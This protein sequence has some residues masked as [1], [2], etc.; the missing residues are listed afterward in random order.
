MGSNLGRESIVKTRTSPTPDEIFRKQ[1]I[2][3]KSIFF[4]KAVQKMKNRSNNPP[5]LKPALKGPEGS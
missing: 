1:E 4:E 2:I 5:I 3:L